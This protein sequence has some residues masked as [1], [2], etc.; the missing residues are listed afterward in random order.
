MNKKIVVLDG[1]TLNPGDLSWSELE[2]FGEV[3]LYD[4]TKKADVAERIKNADIVLTNKTVIDRETMETCE[5]LSYIGVLAT[6]YDV[7]DVK[8]AKELGI[9]VSNVPQY[10]TESV[11]QFAIALLLEICNRVGQHN[12]AT[13]QGKWSYN[14]DWCFWEYPIIE[15]NNKIMGIIGF[16]RIGQQTGK[17]ARSLGMQVL[18]YDSYSTVEETAEV[19]RANQLDDLLSLSDVVVLHCPLTE[20]TREIINKNS[21]NK[22]KSNAILINN[23]RGPLINEVD[24][25]EA[26]TAQQIYAAGIDVVSIEPILEEN[27]LLNCANCFITPHIS[28][29]SKA[30]RKRIMKYTGENI[31]SYLNGNPVNVVS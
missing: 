16:G 2:K 11:S 7:V 31:T 23:S 28:W 17:I 15:L 26:L 10:G 13:K 30:A 29:A 18:Y 6:G 5:K 8:A 9:T 22:M 21:L 3:T 12:D 20:E 1:Y 4:R 14:P 19:R 25:A 27:P 24:L